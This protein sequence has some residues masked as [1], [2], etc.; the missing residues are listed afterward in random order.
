M[1]YLGEGAT[2]ATSGVE[3]FF[4]SSSKNCNSSSSSSSSSSTSSNGGCNTTGPPF[5]RPPTAVDPV[6]MHPT[7]N[8]KEKQ[9][10]C[11]PIQMEPVD[12]SVNSRGGG[13]LVLT[14]D[15]SSRRRSS[16]SPE[17]RK[18]RSSPANGII[19]LRVNKS[20][21]TLSPFSMHIVCTPLC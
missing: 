2:V 15:T 4:T 1:V 14:T 5:R 11:P 3:R 18:R 13:H 10:E 20:G 17:S 16:R 12:L 6:I 8:Y 7:I 19:D 9:A 21:R